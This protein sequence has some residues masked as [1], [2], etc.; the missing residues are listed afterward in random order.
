LKLNT[1]LIESKRKLKDVGI[2]SY[3]LD[4]ELIYVHALSLQG[5]EELILKWDQPLTQKQINDIEKLIE[6]RSKSEPIAYILGYREFWQYKFKVTPAVLTPRPA[7]E[8]IIEETLHAF[9]DKSEKLRICDLG[10][11]SGCLAISLAKIY[12]NATVLAVD[13]SKPAL[14]VAQENASKL[15][16]Q[17]VN[18]ICSDW[19]TDIPAEQFDLIVCN[20]PY[21]PLADMDDLHQDVLNFEPHSALTD[22]RHGLEH[23]QMIAGQMQQYMHTQTLAIF[24]FGINQEH[25]V[26]K[27]FSKN[28]C[29]T[30]KFYQDLQG[31][32][33]GIIIRKAL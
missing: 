11:G 21:I 25:D 10:T 30:V 1:K 26:Q 15:D 27:I 2:E 20:P 6:R 16:A 12:P 23:Y 3:A 32:T 28:A 33:R 4:A 17:N 7:T 5:R 9:P 14:E 22:G 19:L 31:I 8:I 18:F 29:N 13:K 24:E